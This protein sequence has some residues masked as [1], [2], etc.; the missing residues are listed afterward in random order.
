MTKNV[1]PLRRYSIP[2]FVFTKQKSY[3]ICEAKA[4]K[5]ERRIDKSDTVEDFL[6]TTLQ[7][8]NQQM[9]RTQPHQPMGSIQYL[10]NPQPNKSK[11]H[12]LFKYSRH[13]YQDR[14]YTKQTSTDI[15]ELKS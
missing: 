4:D 3:Q 11:G 15:E 13:M 2:K 1:S 9:Y 5:T 14:P 7:T 12:I 6:N 10:Q 8:E